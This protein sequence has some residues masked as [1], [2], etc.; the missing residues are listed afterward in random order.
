MA[1]WP[2]GY[3]YFQSWCISVLTVHS[4]A[5]RKYSLRRLNNTMANYNPVS[6]GKDCG[7]ESRLG[8]IFFVLLYAFS[9]MREALKYNFVRLKSTGGG[10]GVVK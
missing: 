8:R 2:N 5:L 7:F 4:K 6:G 1:W 9:V 10:R 3:G